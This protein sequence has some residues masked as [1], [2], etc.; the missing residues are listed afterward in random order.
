MSTIKEKATKITRSCVAAI[1]TFGVMATN[2]IYASTD[3]GLGILGGNMTDVGIN[4]VSG[5]ASGIFSRV[6]TIICGVIAA[7][8]VLSCVDGFAKYMEAKQDDNT[9]QMSKAGRSMAIGAIMVGAPAVVKFV[10]MG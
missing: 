7:A 9:A 8:G 4:T 6:I 5:G 2:A 3:D 10:L 1:C